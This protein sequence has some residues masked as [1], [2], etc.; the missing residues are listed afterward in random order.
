MTNQRETRRRYMALSVRVGEKEILEH[1]I[2]VVRGKVPVKE[3]TNGK[4]GTK[5]K[6]GESRSGTSTPKKAR[7]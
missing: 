4:N 1:A 6:G 2:E 5:R 7:R 3:E